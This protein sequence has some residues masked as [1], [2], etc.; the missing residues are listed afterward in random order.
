MIAAA[1]VYRAAARVATKPALEGDSLDPL[2]ELERGVERRSCGPVGHE[3]DGLKQTAPAD[4]ADMPVIAEAL[5]QPP[6]ELRA[7]LLHFV[8]QSLLADNFLHFQCGGAR[9]WM[10]PG[11]CDR[12]ETRQTPAGWSR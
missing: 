5:G 1:A 7:A 9:H 10:P 4:I 8:E 12:A 2:I 6:F 11:T 3:F